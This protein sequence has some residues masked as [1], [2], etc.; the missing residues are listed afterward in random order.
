[1][2]LLGGERAASVN[3][4][5]GRGHSIRDVIS[6]VENIT[7][8]NVPVIKRGRRPGDPPALI[9][10]PQRGK[11]LLQWAD[12]KSDLR[13]IVRTAWDWHQKRALEGAHPQ[14]Q[15]ELARAELK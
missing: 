13:T 2:R 5:T 3:L 1:D 9:A 11:A 7:G 15:E 14:K 10:N 8:R 4:G 6:A 12:D